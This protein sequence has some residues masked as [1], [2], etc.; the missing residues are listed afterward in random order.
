MFFSSPRLVN[1]SS[2]SDIVRERTLYVV[3]RPFVVCLSVTFVHH[4]LAIEIFRNVSTTF[5]TLAIP[6]LSIKI[7]RRSSQ[8][9]LSLGGEKQ[10]W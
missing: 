8:G 3:V 1:C 10:Q 2:L 4:T 9:N 5:G 7:S 6:Y